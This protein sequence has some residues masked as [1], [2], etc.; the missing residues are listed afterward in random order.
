MR[1]LVFSGNFYIL[2]DGN[3]KNYVHGGIADN[4]IWKDFKFWER[5]IFDSIEE[6]LAQQRKLSHA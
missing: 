6:E 3:K 1:V 5:A 2:G 4:P